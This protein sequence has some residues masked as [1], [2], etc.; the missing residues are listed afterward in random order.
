MGKVRG[1]IKV[2][3]LPETLDYINKSGFSFSFSSKSFDTKK[4]RAAPI[5][6]ALKRIT[7]VKHIWFTDSG[8][9]DIVVELELDTNYQPKN[10][11]TQ[12]LNIQGVKDAHVYTEVPA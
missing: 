4:S 9:N 12:V 2:K 8:D 3:L 5:L 10:L 11:E 7:G 1:T 6:E